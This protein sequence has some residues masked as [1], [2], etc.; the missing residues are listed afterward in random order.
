[1][2]EWAAIETA[3]HRPGGESV[4]AKLSELVFIEVVRRY[5]ESLPAGRAGWLG[6]LRDP[7]V[8]KALSAMHGA[9]ARSWTTE[10]LAKEAGLSRSVLAQRFR[11]MVGIPPMQY[12]IKWRMQV[13]S[14][15]LGRGSP[16]ANLA[17]VATE[18]GYGSEAAFSRA[19]KKVVG[20]SPSEWR[21][22]CRQYGHEPLLVA[23]RNTSAL[24]GN[25]HVGA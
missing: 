2:I 19:F 11:S 8:G 12:L 15:L 10:Q 21:R 25:A 16:G 5:L 14:E 9:P 1:M 7:F 24:R 13:A 4:L 3:E 17:T 23:N 22:R 18:V 20:M 6:G